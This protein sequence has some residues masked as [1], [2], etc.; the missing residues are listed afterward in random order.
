MRMRLRPFILCLGILGYI[1]GNVISS[2]EKKG[3]CVQKMRRELVS[4]EVY[5]PQLVIS[6]SD[7]T[8]K[9]DIYALITRDS[10]LMKCI[11]EQ[12]QLFMKEASQVCKKNGCG[13]FDEAGCEMII[14][15]Y[16]QPSIGSLEYLARKCEESA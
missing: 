10:R 11:D 14:F 6:G 8:R 12:Y 5:I 1:S 16:F 13:V 4:S 9:S 3:K 2:E 15:E 7:Y